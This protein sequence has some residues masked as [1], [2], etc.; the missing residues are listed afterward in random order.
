MIEYIERFFV[1]IPRTMVV[2]GNR[3]QNAIPAS[4]IKTKKEKKK[5]YNK[6]RETRELVAKEK[7]KSNQSTARSAV[8]P[9]RCNRHQS[10]RRDLLYPTSPKSPPHHRY[11]YLEQRF[12][13][14]RVPVPRREHERRPAIGIDQQLVR[15]KLVQKGGQDFGVPA[16]Q[17]TNK[18]KHK[19]KK[20]NSY[21]PRYPTLFFFIR[22]HELIVRFRFSHQSVSKP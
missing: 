14:R 17:Q 6:T 1:Y 20:K 11:P 10:N 22:Q 9:P 2:V 19:Q 21:S 15:G 4:Q 12:N 18:Q 16:L 5:N 3:C 13:T 8:R 7:K